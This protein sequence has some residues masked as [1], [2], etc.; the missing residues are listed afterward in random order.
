MEK[1]LNRILD[2]P[3]EINGKLPW[4][5]W[6]GCMSDSEGN[7]AK[8][9]GEVFRVGAFVTLVCSVWAS[10]QGMMGGGEG[11]GMIMGIQK[12]LELNIDNLVIK[13][14]SQLVIKQ[15]LKQVLES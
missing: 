6:N 4:N 13:G 3:N 10:V 9:A 11:M 7:L 1:I 5:C 14:D 2:L 8:W 12:A 15:M